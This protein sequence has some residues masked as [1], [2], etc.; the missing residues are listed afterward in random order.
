MSSA[1][2]AQGPRTR[3][4]VVA[5]KPPGSEALAALPEETCQVRVAGSG[6]QALQLAAE[7]PGPDLILLDWQL[8]D[9]TGPEVCRT[10]K[11]T[12]LTAAI[13]IIF[14]AGN[15]NGGD[16]VAAFEAGAAD[17]LHKPLDTPVAVARI[18]MHLAMT[19]QRRALR[20]RT[21]QLEAL[22]REMASFSYSVS[23]DLRAPLRAIRGFG[24][25]LME[26]C[27]SELGDTGRDYLRRVLAA[28][29]R[30]DELIEDLL[31]LSRVT[32]STFTPVTVDLSK[33]VKKVA[34]IICQQ[35]GQEN[36]TIDVQDGIQVQGDLRL[37]R[38]A[39]ENLLENACKF[40]RQTT[41]PVIEFGSREE[42]GTTVYFFRD[43]GIGFD[44]R[45]ADKLFVP[46]QRLHGNAEIP[47]TGIG[48]A[49]V[50]RVI[51]RHGGSIRATSAIGKGAEFSF[52]LGSDA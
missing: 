30:M 14:L 43:N 46:F 37:L 47:G 23:H 35:A 4:L 10:L 18:R 16:E 13:P 12:P 41:H 15:D 3:V 5:D 51:S 25:A 9:T 2:P 7:V 21:E 34:D 6:E 42:N 27:S 40:T 29:Q 24:A 49:T 36:V 38:I 39:V 48:L 8:R 33:L 19:G 17:Y 31:A 45:Y 1:T 44:E 11:A 32:R 20:Q 22:N 28:G 26:E 52:T 50:Q